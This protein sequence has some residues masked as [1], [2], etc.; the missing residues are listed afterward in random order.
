MIQSALDAAGIQASRIESLWWVMLWITTIVTVVVLTTLAT[1][2]IRGSRA[3]RRTV[4]E[5]QLLRYIAAASVVTTVILIG[6][7]TRSIFTSRAL[8]SERGSGALQI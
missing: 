3:Q 7:L 4:D 2:L 1:A 5:S 8:A 6:L